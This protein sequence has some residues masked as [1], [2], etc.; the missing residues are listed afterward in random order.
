MNYSKIKTLLCRYGQDVTLCFSGNENRQHRAFIQPLRYKNKLYLE[1]E[2][3]PVGY[4]DSDTYLY[5]G[6]GDDD[7]GPRIREV[8]MFAGDAEYFFV[9][10]DVVKIKNN[11][12]Y[13]WAIVKPVIAD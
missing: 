13:T 11:C 3:T 2:Y 1:G 6:P 12:I 7:I 10:A 4:F 8:R 5:I 9:R